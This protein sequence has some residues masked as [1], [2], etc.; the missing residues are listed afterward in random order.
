MS[1]LYPQNVPTVVQNKHT[2]VL[3]LYIY[4]PPILPVHGG[5]YC[6]EVVLLTRMLFSFS[7]YFQLFLLCCQVAVNKTHYLRMFHIKSLAAK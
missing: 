3:V 1:L 2:V 5:T 4:I 7:K 6:S